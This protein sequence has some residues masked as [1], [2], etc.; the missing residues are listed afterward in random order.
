ME[1]IGIYH[2]DAGILGELKFIGGRILGLTQCSLCDATHH[3][4]PIGKKAWR[5]EQRKWG[6]LKAIHRN[7]QSPEMASI[8][9]NQTPCIILANA[10]SFTVLLTS[11]EISAC[12]GD[13]QDLLATIRL[14]LAQKPHTI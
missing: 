7:Q 13:L 1:I 8:T 9:D 4:N 10:D 5:D 11:S 12:K 14:K 6:N 3:W 2:A